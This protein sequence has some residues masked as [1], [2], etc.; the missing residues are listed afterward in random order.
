MIINRYLTRE[1]ISVMIAVLVVLVLIFLCTEFSRYLQ[2]AAQGNIPVNALI[3]LLGIAVPALVS[4]LLPLAYFFGL[5]LGY[6]RLYADNE[7]LVMNACGMSQKHLLKVTMKQAI[8]LAILVAILDYWLVPYLAQYKNKILS[9]NAASSVLQTIIPGQFQAAPNGK[10]I[11]YIESLSQ[12]RS[13]LQGIFM[14]Q[15][16]H[17]NQAQKAD[18]ANHSWDVSFAS[19]AYQTE[20]EQSNDTF[21]TSK[22]GYRYVGTPGQAN[23][24]VVKYDTNS[25]RL[26]GSE[27]TSDNGKAQG[28]PTIELLQN[29]ANPAY[30]AEFQWRT[31]LAI[32]VILMALLAVPL[33][34]VKPRQGRFAK[35]LPAI[36]IYIIYAN[37]LYVARS[38]VSQGAVPISI[39]MWWIHFVLLGVI[40]LVYVDENVW[41]KLLRR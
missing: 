39:G 6:G 7:M 17:I 3:K 14:A 29:Y 20:D 32:S 12:D 27:A 10:Q 41:R 18:T 13:K 2:E 24:M 15:P 23:F 37:M 34:K 19:T 21:L 40:A 25:M 4:L 8:V 28:V 26:P 5:L 22:N 1:V 36:L 33:S 35:L 38:W 31:S 16:G 11:F 30:A 9:T